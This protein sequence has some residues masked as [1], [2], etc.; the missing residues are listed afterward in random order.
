MRTNDNYAI[1]HA[2]VSNSFLKELIHCGA[3]VNANNG[4]PLINASRGNEIEN[5]ILLIE[6]GADPTVNDNSPICDVC[7]YADMYTNILSLKCLLDAN[8]DP[9]AQNGKPL[10]NCIRSKGWVEMLLNYGASINYLNE[11]DLCKV[12]FTKD[13]H[14][15]KLLQSHGADF[16][17]INNKL[18]LRNN[19]L[20]EMENLIELLGSNGVDL[21]SFALLLMFFSNLDLVKLY[22]Y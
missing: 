2:W 4:L 6:N 17:I 11:S 8:A 12:I 16:T 21:K 5:I 10:K 14:T 9:N 7:L 19:D 13:F 22:K 18:W 3:D 1:C 20:T 15:A